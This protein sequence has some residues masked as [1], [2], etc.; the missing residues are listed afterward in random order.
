MGVLPVSYAGYQ[1]TVTLRELTSVTKTAEGGSGGS[2][3]LEKW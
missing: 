3:T 1:D 2:E